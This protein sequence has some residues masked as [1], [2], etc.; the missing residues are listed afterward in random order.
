MP[1]ITRR[2]FLQSATLLAGSALLT[3]P[4]KASARVIGANDRLR[5]AVAGLNGRGQA[6]I[7]GWLEQNNV[8]IAYLIDPEARVLARALKAFEK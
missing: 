4:L 3:H 7:S 2:Q 8:E 5:I 6:H 1:P